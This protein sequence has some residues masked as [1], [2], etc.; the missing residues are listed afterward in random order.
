M[1]H[2]NEDN[3]TFVSHTITVSIKCVNNSIT[4]AMT[5]PNSTHNQLT[6]ITNPASTLYF[7]VNSITSSSNQCPLKSIKMTTS[8]AMVSP[9]ADF[10]PN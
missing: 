8:L 1:K 4:L 3:T 10:S 5:A 7:I 9:P 2:T 6:P